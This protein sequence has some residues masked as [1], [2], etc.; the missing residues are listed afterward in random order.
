MKDKDRQHIGDRYVE[1]FLHQVRRYSSLSL[2]AAASCPAQV[3][4][5]VFGQKFARGGRGGGGSDG[6]SFKHE[7]GSGGDGVK[8]NSGDIFKKLSREVNYEKCAVNPVCLCVSVCLLGLCADMCPCLRR[9]SRRV[10]LHP[11]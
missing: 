8:M 10:C 4:D 2:A 6:G 1:I 11:T 7:G 5:T 9:L 3:G